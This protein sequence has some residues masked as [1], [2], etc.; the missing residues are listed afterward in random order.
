MGRQT[1]RCINCGDE[2]GIVAFGLCGK[3]YQRD[4]RVL[5]DRHTPGI[6]REHR[7]LFRGLASVMCGLGDLGV[8]R[9]ETIRVR[10][11]LEPYLRPIADFLSCKLSD[12]S[13]DE[14]LKDQAVASLHVVE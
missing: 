12:N 7:K 2:R 4:V 1:G 5:P 14:V 8:S 11:M 9:A 3:C 6:R 10:V 13:V